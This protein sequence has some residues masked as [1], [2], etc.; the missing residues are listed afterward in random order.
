MLK[1]IKV[2]LHEDQYAQPWLFK[3]RSVPFK[4]KD[5]IECELRILENRGNNQSYKI[6]KVSAPI[7][8]VLKRD[9]MIRICCDY[10]TTINQVSKIE[11]YPSHKKMV[12][13]FSNLSGGSF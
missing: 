4:H 11:S 8:P 3:S 6:F 12:E 1:N 9:G 7:V 13:L 2:L 10:K 5:K